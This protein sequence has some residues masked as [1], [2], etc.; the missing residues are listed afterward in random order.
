MTQWCLSVCHSVCLLL[1][2][3][4]YAYVSIFLPVYVCACM[5]VYVYV[6]VSESRERKKVEE[7]KGV[8]NYITM[9]HI[10][11]QTKPSLNL[12]LFYLISF[13]FW[14]GIWSKD[15]CF[16][17]TVNKRI[18]AVSSDKIWKLGGIKYFVSIL[19]RGNEINHFCHKIF[20]IKNMTYWIYKSTFDRIHCLGGKNSN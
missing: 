13:F 3:C 11:V 14:Q 10:V 18:M 9:F 17:V 15:K 4:V 16:Q 7:S 19:F 12:F 5:Y 8:S 20:T 6:C 2:V 1:S